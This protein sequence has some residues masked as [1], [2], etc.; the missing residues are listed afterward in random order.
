MSPAFSVPQFP[1]RIRTDLIRGKGKNKED[2]FNP[3]TKNA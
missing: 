2:I 1:V 3:Y